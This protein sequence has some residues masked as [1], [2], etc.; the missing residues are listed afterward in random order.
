MVHYV[1]RC[2]RKEAELSRLSALPDIL[3]NRQTCQFCPQSFNCALYER[4]VSSRWS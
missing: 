4:Y 2:V 3:T 1:H